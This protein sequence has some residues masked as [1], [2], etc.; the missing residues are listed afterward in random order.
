M[1]IGLHRAHRIKHFK[2][3]NK[4][5]FFFKRKISRK[6]RVADIEII[7]SVGR[8]IFAALYLLA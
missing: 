4:L 5:N 1:K 7:E 8:D 3:P 6:T 2:K